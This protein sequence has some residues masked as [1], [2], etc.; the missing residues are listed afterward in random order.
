MARTAG[1]GRRTSAP[2][3]SWA[4]PTACDRS[5]TPGGWP[6]TPQVTHGRGGHATAGLRRQIHRELGR[7]AT[8]VRTSAGGCVGGERRAT[9]GHLPQGYLAGCRQAAGQRCR[10]QSVVWEDR[11][12]GARNPGRPGRRVVAAT[13]RPRSGEAVAHRGGVYSRT[14]LDRSRRP[15]ATSASPPPADGPRYPPG[16]PRPGGPRPGPVPRRRPPPP[17]AEHTSPPVGGPVPYSAVG[18]PPSGEVRERFPPVSVTAVADQEFRVRRPNRAGTPRTGPEPPGVAGPGGEVPHW[19]AVPPRTP[20]RCRWDPR[21]GEQD[22][23]G[24]VQRDEPAP[25]VVPEDPFHPSPWWGSG[26]GKRPGWRRRPAPPG[27]RP[28]VVDTQN[29]LARSDGVMES[30][31][32]VHPW[33]ACPSTPPGSHPGYRRPPDSRPGNPRGRPARLVPSP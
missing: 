5:S 6:A 31:G 32:D 9:E 26:R 7:P 11:A 27:W 33:R 12:A 10:V 22:V 13:S 3:R 15:P 19:T 23:S 1:S 4:R 14:I 28:H 17:T 24:L 21:N 18:R 2:A 16:A 20:R 8:S 30:A 25:R 29:P